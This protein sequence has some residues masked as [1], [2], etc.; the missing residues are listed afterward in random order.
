[1]TNDQIISNVLKIADIDFETNKQFTQRCMDEARKDER[2]KM[3]DEGYKNVIIT[4]KKW[5]P[6]IH[7]DKSELDYE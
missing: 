4:E 7:I 5:Q 3:L 6:K 1:M 2:Q